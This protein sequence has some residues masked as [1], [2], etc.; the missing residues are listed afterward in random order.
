[1]SLH[2]LTWASG[3]I[4]FSIFLRVEI[5]TV[6][7]NLINT[8]LGWEVLASR[9]R[10]SVWVSMVMTRVKIE[11]YSLVS[12]RDGGLTRMPWKRGD[13]DFEFRSS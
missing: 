10:L 11:V 3:E 2:R 5:A 9:M 1:M 7:S 6:T 8:S 4:W 12:G 13:R